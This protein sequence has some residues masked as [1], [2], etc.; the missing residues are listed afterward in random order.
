MELKQSV[1]TK[2]PVRLR[3]VVDGSALTG[4]TYSQVSVYI[5]KHG[6][7]SVLKALAPSEW[8]EVDAVGMPG[9]YDLSLSASDLDTLGFFKYYASYPGISMQYP[10]LIQVVANIESDTFTR[11]GAPVG[12][13][14]SADLQGVEASLAAD[15]AAV[16]AD[17]VE[18]LG[19]LHK[20]AVVVNQSYNA[21]GRLVGATLRVYDS[22]GN[23]LLN[24]GV[25]GLLSTYNILATY[26]AQQHET[27]YRL[28]KP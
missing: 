7:A 14:I 6:G 25:T 27:L 24:D 16:K 5:Q 10:G 4:V 17:T 21:A 8:T 1:A 19:L 12:A 13:S 22:A 28:T 23:A 20:N 3:A 9:E 15:I 11:L 18:V 2:V 26:D